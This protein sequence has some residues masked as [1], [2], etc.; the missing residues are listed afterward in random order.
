MSM[1]KRLSV[2]R[3]RLPLALLGLLPALAA[4]VDAS[5][6]D[7]VRRGDVTQARR[8]L[9]RTE[10]NRAQPDGST[11]LAWAVESQN[12]D[13]VRLLLAQG[14]RA[15]GVGVPALAPLM[16]ACEY[17]N[18]AMLDALLAAGADPRVARDD[19]ITPLALC[20][21]SASPQILARLIKAG[22]AVDAPDVRGQT[23]LMHAAAHGR[24][25]NIALLQQR[26]ADINRRTQQGFTPLF[27]ALKSGKPEA[28][29]A[30]LAAGGDADYVAPDGTSAVQLAMYQKD[31]GFAARMIERGADLK[32]CDRQGHRLLHAAVLVRQ[33]QLV[34]LLLAK[35]ADP[36]APTGVSQVKLRYESN[37]KTGDYVEPL[38]TPLQLASEL[39][40]VGLMQTL[41]AAGADPKFADAEGTGLVLAATSSGRPAAL[42]LALQLAPDANVRAANGQTPLHW[43]L[44]NG[45]ASEDDTVAMMKL[46][47]EHGARSD[48]RDRDGQTAADLA[49]D[50][51]F[52]LKAAFDALYGNTKVQTL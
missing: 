34:Q 3:L 5:W 19:G 47:A 48:I 23:P 22:A 50:P 13:M 4:A 12:P 40:D 42:A 16:I 43:L 26:G 28:P 35:G 32:A 9:V 37:F 2:R 17:G 21:G 38:K 45:G 1:P 27:F 10:L 18:V 41:L 36:N 39:G 51:H 11:P 33:P 25:D 49:G 8:H 20:A 14:A 52:K 29:L 6:L 15:H 44:S 30:V 7:A 31:Y 24:V 46:L